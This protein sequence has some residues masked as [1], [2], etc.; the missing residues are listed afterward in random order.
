M[1][2]NWY[3]TEYDDWCLNNTLC[4]EMHCLLMHFQAQRYF[5]PTLQTQLTAS[6]ACVI[7][8]L[9]VHLSPKNLAENRSNQTR[10]ML[11]NILGDAT[12]YRPPGSQACP[13]TSVGVLQQANRAPDFLIDLSP[14]MKLQATDRGFGRCI[15]HFALGEHR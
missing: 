9:V 4:E 8:S 1:F 12:S 2:S 13:S 5:R 6:S 10:N 7:I 14:K 11:N 3:P 15:P